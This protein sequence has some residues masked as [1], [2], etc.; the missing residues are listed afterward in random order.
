M[1]HLDRVVWE[2]LRKINKIPATF[3]FYR[4]VAKRILHNGKVYRIPFGPAKGSKWKYCKDHQIWMLLGTYEPRVSEYILSKIGRG[5]VFYDI[6]ANAGYFSLIAARVVGPEGRVI[7]FE[8]VPG[9]AELISEQ[10]ELN[11]LKGVSEVR[12]IAIANENKRSRFVIS[13]T[14]AN[15][16]LGDIPTDAPQGN[17][18]GVDIE[19]KSIT[20]DS[21]VENSRL[22]SFIK[23]DIEGAEVLALQGAQMLLSS[24]RKPILM[25]SVHSAKLENETKALMIRYGYNI[26]NLP[27]FE[28]M[29]IGEP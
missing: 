17:S 19:V 10:L 2:Q 24:E 1:P 29:V 12:R 27:H 23:M 6:G 15:S 25:I 22:P 7:A 5:S 20:L 8:P 18:N 16:H 14:N 26:R 28:Q 21:V 11:G 3:S 13:E 4:F 9:N